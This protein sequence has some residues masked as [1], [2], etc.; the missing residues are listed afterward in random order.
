MK[1][2]LLAV[3]VAFGGIM[4]SGQASAVPL[5]CNNYATLGALQA[6]GSCVDNTDQDLLLTFGATTLPLTSSFDLVEVPGVLEFYA[7]NVNF[8]AGFNPA[9]PVTFS[10]T[11]TSLSPKEVLDGANFDTNVQGTGFLATKQIFDSAGAPL[12]TLTSVNGSR[13]PA[14][15][16]T[17]FAGHSSINV[18]DTLNPGTGVYFGMSNSYSVTPIPEPS[19]LALLGLGFLGMAFRRRR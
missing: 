8:G 13:D 1:A 10:Y 14:Q 11:L 5:T 17:P 15:G 9:G 3:M 2:K 19:T 16:E 6:A 7:V 18:L 4:L 12:L